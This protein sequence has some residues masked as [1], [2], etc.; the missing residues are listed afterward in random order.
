MEHI[1]GLS[2]I[3]SHEWLTEME[4]STEVAWITAPSETISCNLMG[5]TIWPYYSPIVGMNIISKAWAK[6]L[7]PNK[8]LIPS[9]KLLRTPRITLESYGVMRLIPIRIR[10]SKYRLDF[11]IYDILDMSLLIGVP[12]GTLF[13]KWPN[14]GLLNLRLGSSPIVVSLERSHNAIVEP[15]PE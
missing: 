1:K 9:H 14:Q 10:G 15:K 13:Q 4:L 6:A 11:H 12:F 3:M 2:A 7:C 8:S 5:T